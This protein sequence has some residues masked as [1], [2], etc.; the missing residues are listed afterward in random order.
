MHSSYFS[1]ILDFN[2][3]YEENGFIF[4][5][6][7]KKIEKILED[8]FGC[9]F[10]NGKGFVRLDKCNLIYALGTPY[11]EYGKYLNLMISL[12]EFPKPKKKPDFAYLAGVFDIHGKMRQSSSPCIYFSDERVREFL[13]H[14]FRRPVKGKRFYLQSKQEIV[15]TLND[16]DTYLIA[17][18]E[19]YRNFIQKHYEQKKDNRRII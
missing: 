6:M 15:F 13:M 3:I 7:P 9:N 2:T 4:Y 8:N 14:T 16:I 10:K 18:G 19:S 12:G 1:S 5:G 11:L 17:K